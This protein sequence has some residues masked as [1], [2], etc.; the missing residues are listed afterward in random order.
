R[1]LLAC[2]SLMKRIL[3]VT[4]DAEYGSST[5]Q[6]R[7][8]AKGL[9]TDRFE[10]RACVLGPDGPARYSIDET[11]VPVEVLGW[12]RVFDGPP[13]W[14]L[15]RLLRDYQPQIVHIWQPQALRAVRTVTRG[16]GSAR[17]APYQLI[18]S[19]PQPA[20]PATAWSAFDRWLLAGV[21]R[22]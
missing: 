4:P 12:P 11:R 3:F 2:G 9:P 17:R 15:R 16:G 7:Q 10:V 21:D 18:V 19:A 22:V 20:L 8:L 1:S 14:R 6:V 5:T 13:L